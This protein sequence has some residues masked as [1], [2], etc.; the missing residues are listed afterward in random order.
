MSTA[1]VELD[2]FGMEKEK[3]SSSRWFASSSAISRSLHSQ[4]SFRGLQ[5][6]ISRI[7]PELIKSVIASNS[8]SPSATPNIQRNS[9][10][11]LP[12]HVPN[13]RPTNLAEDGSKHTAPLTIFYNGTVT[14]FNVSPDEAKNILKL[15]P[16]ASSKISEQESK[17]TATSSMDRQKLL[18]TL[19]GDLPLFRRKSL[20]MFLEKRKERLKILSPYPCNSYSG[21]GI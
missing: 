9:L 4:G 13:L 11:C 17:D 2:F 20:E 21:H 5:S 10:P 14:I 19:G 8:F 15:A 7:N 16:E 3:C 1:A 12:V 18:S 6:A